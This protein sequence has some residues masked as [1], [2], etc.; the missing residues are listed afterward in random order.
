MICHLC[1]KE[2]VE[3]VSEVPARHACSPERANFKIVFCSKDCAR[4][5]QKDNYTL[6]AELDRNASDSSCFIHE[7]WE[8][9]YRVGVCR[10]TGQPV[11]A[12]PLQPSNRSGQPSDCADHFSLH[13]RYSSTVESPVDK[14]G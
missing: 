10:I 7:R 2:V 11:V 5:W 13:S 6:W 1:V 12:M 4:A 8:G 3:V 9:K 14:V